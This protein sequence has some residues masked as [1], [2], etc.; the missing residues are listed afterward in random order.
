MNS[1]VFHRSEGSQK[2]M[3]WTLRL[4]GCI[5]LAIS[6]YL[7]WAAFTS[8][9]VAGCGGGA[10]FD[11][12]HVLSSRWSTW[13]GI[14]VGAAAASLYG[15]LLAALYFCGA[16]TPESLR[17]LGWNVVAILATSAGM[18]A[19]WFIGLQVFVLQHLCTYCLG[20]HFCGLAI[21]A[22]LLWQ[23]PIPRLQISKLSLVGMGGVA[24]LIG[25]QL[26]YAPPTFVVEVHEPVQAPNS[27]DSLFAAPSDD[28]IFDFN[29]DA[30]APAENDLFMAPGFEEEEVT[31]EL[32]PASEEFVPVAAV[33]KSGL[34]FIW[35]LVLLTLVVPAD[36]AKAQGTAE[37]RVV[38]LGTT[39][40]LDVRQWP[41][42]GDPN[43]E[44]IFVE[45]FDYTCPHC[46]ATN[47]SIKSVCSRFGSRL[48]I[49][50]LPVPLEASCNPHAS[51]S[52]HT[53]SCE[54]ARLAVAV[55]R[56]APDKYHEFHNWLFESPAAR[57]TF[58]ARSK[59]G[60]LVGVAA[61]NREIGTG[62]PGQYVEKHVELY[63]RMGAGSVPKL[64][65]PTVTLVGEV[66]SATYLGE[67]IQKQFPN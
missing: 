60:Q 57:S 34:P 2:R 17:R 10:V 55:W 24:V 26:A 9:K 46:R 66:G 39:A 35:L 21:C 16:A 1:S 50:A 15:S 51:G 64:V 5:A 42:I 67:T 14:P 23:Q 7:G 30:A 48:A 18:A 8:S 62:I 32:P 20:A 53:G 41:L 4:L 31:T 44:Y 13:F 25:G 56:I 11:C 63:K 29:L 36:S 33:D 28:G 65:F 47:E 61:L 40:K 22:I 54:I 52:G 37:R 43:A 6:C 27:D 12:G 58:E 19:L 49:V 59:A 3:I 45:M 38:A